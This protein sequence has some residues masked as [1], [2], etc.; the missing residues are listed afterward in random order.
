MNA[1]LVP[2]QGVGA[3]ADVVPSLLSG[4]GVAGFADRLRLNP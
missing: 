1:P 4:L 2:A 3:L